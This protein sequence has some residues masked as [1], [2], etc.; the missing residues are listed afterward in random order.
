M[1]ETAYRAWWP[2]HLRSARGEALTPEER[3]TYESGLSALHE[4]EHT[5]GDTAALRDRRAQV[6]RLRAD[7]TELSARRRQLDQE[8]AAL[9][10]ALSLGT[11]QALGVEG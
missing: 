5:A 4:E 11:K 2:L 7:N 9:E 10:E 8:I 1:D 6:S 3:A